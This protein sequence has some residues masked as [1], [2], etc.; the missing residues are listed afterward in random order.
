MSIV[1]IFFGLDSLFC[2]YMDLILI[3]LLVIDLLKVFLKQN[4]LL[5]RSKFFV[6]VA[7]E[8]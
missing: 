5:N 4:R 8:P 6:E 2:P 3:D 1:V 7:Q